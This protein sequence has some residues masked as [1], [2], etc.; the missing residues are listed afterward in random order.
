MAVVQHGQTATPAKGKVVVNLAKRHH[1]FRV[2]GTLFEPKNL[3]G[4]FPRCLRARPS[5]I[6][7]RVGSLGWEGDQYFHYQR[8]KNSEDRSN[9]PNL[10]KK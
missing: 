10:N 3:A 2:D 4:S 1:N 8:Y 9:K 7:S 5:E 6:Y